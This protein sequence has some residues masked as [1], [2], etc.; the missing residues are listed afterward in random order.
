M[1]N[2]LVSSA[3]RFLGTLNR[4]LFPERPSILEPTELRPRKVPATYERV[5]HV[6]LTDEIGRFLF[7]EFAQHREGARGEEEIGWVLLGVRENDHALVLA[8]LP[9]GAQR[10]AGVAHVQF[11]SVAQALASRIVRQWDKRLSIVGVVHTHPG[12]MRHP[13]DGDFQGDSQWVGQLRGGEG[14]FGIGTADGPEEREPLVAVQPEPHLQTLGEL[15]F[16]WYGL[17]EGDRRYVPLEVRLTL[18]PDLSAPLHKVWPTVEHHAEPLERLC[19]QLAG[20]TFAVMKGQ[21]GPA[22]AASVK[23]AE[24][25]AALRVVLE[26]PDIRYFLQRGQ[27]FLAVDPPAPQVDR[28][29]FLLLA[30]MAGQS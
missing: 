21:N 13:S 29:V 20:M 11:N 24:P 25:E 30:E 3:S 6:L 14:V 15:C 19:H 26:G 17:R 4:S 8:T 16:S 2:G 18:G 9:A 23:T 12:K 5:R 10:S 1:I 22:L 7:R 28:S 27:D